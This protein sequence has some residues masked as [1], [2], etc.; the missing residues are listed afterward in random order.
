MFTSRADNASGGNYLKTGLASFQL[1]GVNPTAA[2]IMEWTGRT[3][4]QEPKYDLKKWFD[5]EFQ[6]RPLTFYL[7]NTEGDIVRYKLDIGK[8]PRVTKNGNYQVCT[9]NGS[10]VWAKASGSPDVKPE[11]ADH[12][13]LVIGEEELISFVGR[14]INFD[15]KNPDGNLY[16]EME[17]AGVTAQ[18]LYDGNY[19]GINAVGKWGQ[20][21]DKHIIMM[22]MVNEGEGTDKDGNTVTKN[23]QEVCGRT[24]LWFSGEVNDYALDRTK[25]LYEKSLEVAPGA[26][27]AYPL[28]KGFFTYKYQDYKKSD[29]VNAVPDNPTTST[30]TEWKS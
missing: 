5:T 14:L 20:E 16:K 2:Q 19:K 21:N 12:R 1:L 10:I 3:D 18:L 15:Y 13:P 9:S 28:I 26:T 6:C 8:D 17:A 29:C 22:M 4:V 23:Y 25:T 11:F 30:T 27:Q 24:E 7:K